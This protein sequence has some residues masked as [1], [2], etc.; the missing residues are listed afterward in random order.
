MGEHVAVSLGEQGDVGRPAPRR[1]VREAGLVSEDRLAR[2]G[3][4]HDDVE[5][6][7]QQATPQQPIQRGDTAGDTARPLRRLLLTLR[8]TLTTFLVMSSPCPVI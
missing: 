6:A 2:P 4:A 5:V 3:G 1:D 8:H 7:A